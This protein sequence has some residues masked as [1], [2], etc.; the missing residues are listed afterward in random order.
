MRKRA[1]AAAALAVALGVLAPAAQAKEL[2]ANVVSMQ[3]RLTPGEPV[4]IVFE[5]YVLE[6]RGVAATEHPIAGAHDLA[7]LLISKGQTER[8]AASELGGGRYSTEVV[9]PH[10]GDWKLAVSVGDHAPIPLG[11]GAVRIDEASAFRNRLPE[12]PLMLAGA[13]LLAFLHVRSRRA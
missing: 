9:F 4:P 3:S 13:A 10:A 5:L 2:Q 12:L 7:V 11:K 6:G 8:F 1:L